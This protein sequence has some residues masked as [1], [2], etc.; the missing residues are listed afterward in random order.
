MIHDWFSH[1]QRARRNP[2]EVE[3]A[4]DD[5]WPEHPMRIMRTIGRPDP[6]ASAARPPT[7]V[8]TE[9][10]WWDASQIYGSSAELPDVLRTGEGGKLRRRA[11]RLVPLPPTTRLRPADVS[12]GSGSG[13]RCCR[14]CSCAST[15]RSATGSPRHYPTGTTTS[16][17]SAR[18][19]STPRS[20]PRS[21]PSSGRRRSSPPDHATAH[22]RQ[23]V[24]PGRRAAHDPFGRLSRARTSA[25]SRGR[26]EHYGVPVRADRGVRRGLP[27]ASADP[28]RLRLP[29]CRRRPAPA[30]TA[31]SREISGPETRECCET[32]PM[33]DLLYSFGTEHPGPSSASTTSR[34]TCS[35]SCGPTASCRT[36][37]P[38]TSCAAGS[39]ACRATTSSAACST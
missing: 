1:G 20:S 36:W 19:W 13:S 37:P 39:R 6:T 9:S 33:A 24:G 14:R 27:D 23:L 12:P 10:H 32:A 18:G 2:W 5:D 34:S 15:T 22:A 8:N 38:S 29:R 25:A 7:Y 28:G 35:T 21:T 26:T 17:S 11:R 3:L 16:S 4:P 30:A 31:R